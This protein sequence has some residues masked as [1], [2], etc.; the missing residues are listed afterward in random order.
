[1]SSQ[2]L[3]LSLLVILAFARVGLTQYLIASLNSVESRN[4]LFGGGGD[5]KTFGGFVCSIERYGSACSADQKAL[6]EWLSSNDEIF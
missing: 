1:M 2:Y 5:A 3:D 6:E 4:L